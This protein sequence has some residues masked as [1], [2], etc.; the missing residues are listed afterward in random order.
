MFLALIGTLVI[1]VFQ[2][3]IPV[4]QLAGKF[5]VAIHELCHALVCILTGGEVFQVIVHS[6]ISGQTIKSGGN[7]ALVLMSGYLGASLIGALTI[8]AFSKTKRVQIAG[9]LLGFILLVNSLTLLI[10]ILLKS[11]PEITSDAQAF[12][13]G[14]APWLSAQ[15]VAGFWIFVVVAMTFVAI[16]YSL[17]GKNRAES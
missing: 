15:Q 11:G 12:S 3:Q 7:T 13:E 8:F 2:E 14:V 1:C 9:Y 16:Y 4:L 5:S 17:K 6:S 10:I